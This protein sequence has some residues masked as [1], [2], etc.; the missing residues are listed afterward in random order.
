MPGNQ[1]TCVM[2]QSAVEAA[3][4]PSIDFG[5]AKSFIHKVKTRPE[6]RPV[7][8]KLRRLPLSVRDA[9]SAELRY[10]EQHGII[11]KTDSS[12]WVSPIAV[13]QKKTGGIRMYVDLLEPNKAVVV[14]SYPLPLIEDILSELRGAVMFST[15][16]LKHVY[17]S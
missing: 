14:D 2:L 15:L 3:V 4:E 16:D 9:V 12:E 1:P 13:T 7:Q 6:V 17:H 5:C 8:Q 11:E 10:L